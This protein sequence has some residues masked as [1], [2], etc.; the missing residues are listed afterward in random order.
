MTASFGIG[1]FIYGIVCIII[2]ACIIYYFVKD[3]K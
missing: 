2:G 1:M 3:I